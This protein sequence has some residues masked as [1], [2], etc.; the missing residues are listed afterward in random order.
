[1]EVKRAC[2][3]EQ[4]TPNALAGH[5]ELRPR[6]RGRGSGAAYLGN[7]AL[8]LLGYSY[9]WW[10]VKTADCRKGGMVDGQGQPQHVGHW[11]QKRAMDSFVS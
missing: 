3:M 4:S 9:V 8:M 5:V 2:W 6:R 1:M 10:Q 7:D 11:Q